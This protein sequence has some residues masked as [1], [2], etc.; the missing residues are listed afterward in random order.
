MSSKHPLSDFTLSP[1]NQTNIECRQHTQQHEAQQQLWKCISRRVSLDTSSL[2]LSL[3][4]LGFRVFQN[5]TPSSRRPQLVSRG[6]VTLTS[7][8]ASLELQ[9]SWASASVVLRAA[10]IFRSPAM[11]KLLKTLTRNFVNR[12]LSWWQVSQVHV[13]LSRVSVPLGKSSTD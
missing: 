11:H 5:Y 9:S 12:F 4:S 8:L 13:C 1:A 3:G 2:M 10:A 7:W 6:L